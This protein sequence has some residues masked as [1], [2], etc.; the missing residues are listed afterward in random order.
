MGLSYIIKEPGYTS[1]SNQEKE[2]GNVLIPTIYLS[3]DFPFSPGGSVF[4]GKWY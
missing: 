3:G 2:R 4:T 1:T